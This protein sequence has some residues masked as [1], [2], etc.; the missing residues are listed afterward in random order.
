MSEFPTNQQ[1]ITNSLYRA[2]QEKAEAVFDEMSKVFWTMQGTAN[3]CAFLAIDDAVEAMQQA[4]WMRQQV[5]VKAQRALQEF[6]K[7][8]KLVFQHFK[9]MDDDRYFLWS[10]M[11]SRAADSLQ[12]DADKLY[13]AIK[14]VIDRY[15]V[16][17]SDIHAKIQRAM[18]LIDLAILMYNTMVERYQRQTIIPIGNAFNGGKLTAVQ[19]N[20]REVAHLTGRSVLPAIDLNQDKTCHLAIKVIL[21]KY[22][23]ADFLNEAAGEA[24]RLNPNCAKYA[25]E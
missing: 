3:Q 1:K 14:S 9:I 11:T 13:F 20:W 22:Q 8:E 17:D 7:Y 18:A 10:D 4:G 16:K 2:Q 21:T 24:L 23:Q 12:G 5:K 15:N 19:S 25:E 6:R